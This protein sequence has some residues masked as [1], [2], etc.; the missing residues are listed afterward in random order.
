MTNYDR[1][2]KCTPEQLA[3]VFYNLKENAIYANG[4]LLNIEENPKDFLLWLNKES[5]YLDSQIFE[6]RIKKVSLVYFDC[7]KGSYA[8]D[9]NVPFWY[10]DK[11]II[12]LFKEKLDVYYSPNNCTIV[13]WS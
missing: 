1:F 6:M 4:R 3:S 5:D 9:I 12:P 2:M 8:V 10:E 11:E 7:I 13:Y